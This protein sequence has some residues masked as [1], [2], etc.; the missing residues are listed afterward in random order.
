MQAFIEEKQR[1]REHSG[2]S[3]EPAK[4]KIKT[5]ADKDLPVKKSSSSLDQLVHAVQAK[6]N[7]MKIASKK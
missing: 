5:T 1:R 4:K 2:K 7:R 6:S 3:D